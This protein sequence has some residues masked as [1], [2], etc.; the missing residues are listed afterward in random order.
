MRT[1]ISEKLTADSLLCAALDVGEHLL[2]NGGE[3]HRVEDTIERICKS[4]G[5]V[6]VEVFTITNLITASV[7]MADG[8]MSQQMRRITDSV[9]NMYAVEE[10]NE[11]S[12][13]LCSG[14]LHINSLDDAIAKIKKKK[15]YP[16]WLT[17]VGAMCAAGGFA[18][19]FGGTLLDGVCAAA[20]GVFLTFLD[21]YVPKI[22]NQMVMTA[23]NSFVSGILSIL[24]VKFG[25]GVNVDKIIIGAIMIL[26]PGIALNNSIRDMIT[27]DVLAGFL[28]FIQS[29]LLAL[30]IAAGFAAAILLFGG[31][32]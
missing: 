32:V 7:R 15:V 30:M 3:V 28:R 14:K 21:K 20:V 25:L 11:I 22:A 17:F 5:A 9:N 13:E 18:I 8:D 16:T 24:L 6:H 1:I 2:K 29:I 26:I 19:F 27:G 4:F 31:A 10:L 12:R 23:I